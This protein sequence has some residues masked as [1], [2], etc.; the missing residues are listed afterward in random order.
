RDQREAAQAAGG[1][2]DVDQPELGERV[3]EGAQE[4]RGGAAVAGECSGGPVGVPAGAG[5]R[6]LELALGSLSADAGQLR[7][8]AAGGEGGHELRFGASAPELVHGPAFAAEGPQPFVGD[9]AVGA[10][11]FED[12]AHPAA[13]HGSVV[14]VELK[15]A[16]SEGA[17]GGSVELL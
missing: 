2:D 15:G 1:L 3:E 11:A 12:A 4:G 16:H 13:A 14:P 10:E 17:F 8:G 5:G 9:R 7:E 6:V